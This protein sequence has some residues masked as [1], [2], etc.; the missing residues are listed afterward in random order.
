M[1]SSIRAGVRRDLDWSQGF[2]YWL[3][4]FAGFRSC[5]L[6]CPVSLEL[7]PGTAQQWLP[8]RAWQTP[9]I[10]RSEKL[11][12]TQSN[13]GTDVKMIVFWNTSRR[14]VSGA[15]PPVCGK[16]RCL[17]HGA[18]EPQLTEIFSLHSVRNSQGIHSKGHLLCP[19]GSQMGVPFF[20]PISRILVS[21]T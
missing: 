7:L 6:N 19:V 14:G 9:P 15:S 16:R 20:Q 12:A 2:F 3:W 17:P 1:F 5:P 4:I 13:S 21:P 18:L 8:R 10:G 11:S